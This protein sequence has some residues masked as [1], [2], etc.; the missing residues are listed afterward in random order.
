MPWLDNDYPAR[1]QPGIYVQKPDP[2]RCQN[3]PDA[4]NIYVLSWGTYACYVT[5]FLA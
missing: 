2:E 4:K 3:T 5:Q 1:I